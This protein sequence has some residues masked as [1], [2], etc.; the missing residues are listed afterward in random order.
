MLIRIQPAKKYHLEKLD[1]G[2]LKEN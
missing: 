1:L 2:M